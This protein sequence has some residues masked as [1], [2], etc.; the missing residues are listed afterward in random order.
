MTVPYKKVGG[1]QSII[2]LGV[3]IVS[4]AITSNVCYQCQKTF[5]ALKPHFVTYF[6]KPELELLI[7]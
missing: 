7:G 4:S 2:F 5:V 1:A 6:L 3:K